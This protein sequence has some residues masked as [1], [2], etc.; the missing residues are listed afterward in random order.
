MVQ[1]V[2]FSLHTVVKVQGKE[3]RSRVG[4]TIDLLELSNKNM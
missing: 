1:D 4:K 3:R 2:Y